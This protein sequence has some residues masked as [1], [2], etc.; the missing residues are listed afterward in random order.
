MKELVKLKLEVDRPELVD[1]CDLSAPNP[2]LLYNLKAYP[3]TV[4]VPKNWEYKKKQFFFKRSI[5]KEV[6]EL[7]KNIKDTGISQL[8]DP[9]TEKNTL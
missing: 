9:M 3:N 7:P 4:P 6:Y 2:Q 5:Y 1:E 8:R